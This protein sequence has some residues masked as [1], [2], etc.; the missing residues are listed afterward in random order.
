MTQ[1]RTAE[2]LA[3]LGDERRDV[4]LRAAREL[5]TDHRPE[6]TA[7]LLDRLEVE[8][9]DFVLEDLTW[10]LAQHGTLAVEGLIRRLSSADAVIRRQ[11][12]HV[13]SKIARPEFAPHLHGVIAD[14]DPD[15]AIKAYRAAANTR[16]PEVVP[17]LAARLGDGDRLQ[18]DQL[19]VAFAGLGPIAVPALVAALGDGDATVR[20]HAA[21]ALAQVGAPAA[22][23][24]VEALVAATAD[25]D[26]EIR[27]AAV[28]ALTTLGE[29]VAG[30][31]LA[32]LADSA[33]ARVRAIAAS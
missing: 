28:M 26:A 17:S 16:N 3:I 7:A 15:V 23:E 30:P 10:A 2:L 4:R 5:A 11:A 8:R 32:A 31:A 6:V 9:D 18:R 25:P 12:A 14:E 20:L 19:A 22:D 13:L 1:D 29:D 24:A 21:E 27:L 33:D